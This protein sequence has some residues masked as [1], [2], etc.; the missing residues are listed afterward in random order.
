M[1]IPTPTDQSRTYTFRVRDGIRYSTG[2]LLQPADFRR[3]F[4]RGFIVTHDAGYYG[5]IVGAAECVAKPAKCDLSRGIVTNDAA[6]TV[7]F[8]LRTPDPDFL[9]KLALPAAFAL[10]PGTPNRLAR[11]HPLP[12]TGPYMVGS[13]T[14][15]R[16]FLLV[17]NPRFKEWSKAAQ[18]DGY[19]DRIGLRAAPRYVRRSMEPRTWP[20]SAFR[21]TSNTSSGRSTQAR[22]MKT[23]SRA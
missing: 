18:P 13:N 17:R 14:A 23:P 16:V 5:T 9:Y 11:T 6:R 10:P 4:E 15:G 21:P 3:A 8:H 2:Q 1:T 22:S 19:P 20:G 12:A 7:T